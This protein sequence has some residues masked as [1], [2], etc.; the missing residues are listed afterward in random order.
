M[1]KYPSINFVISHKKITNA[2]LHFIHLQLGYCLSATWLIFFDD[3]DIWKDERIHVY[4]LI[5]G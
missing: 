4:N 2:A 3:D 5:Y 1:Q